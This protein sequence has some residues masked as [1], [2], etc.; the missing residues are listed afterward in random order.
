M[1]WTDP[2]TWARLLAGAGCILCADIHLEANP[3][4]FLVAELR[5][6]YLRLARNQYRRGWVIVALKRHANELFEL[7]DRE[8][9]DYARDIA[10]AAAALQEVFTPVKIN[11]AILGN[12]CPHLHCHLLPQFFTDDPP[13]LLDMADDELLLGEQEYAQIVA[14]LRR[15]LARPAPAPT[16]TAHRQVNGA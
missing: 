2:T 16:R 10:D 5:Q 8:L 15:A 12:Q 14:D 3:F 13:R 4:S 1:A 6:S 9:A 11:Y 7:A